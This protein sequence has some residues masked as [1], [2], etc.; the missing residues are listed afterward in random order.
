MVWHI[1]IISFYLHIG[2]FIDLHRKYSWSH[3]QSH[4]KNQKLLCL[5]LRTFQRWYIKA[6][7]ML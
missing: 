1:Q 3:S 6:I 2:K 7:N 4:K 5:R